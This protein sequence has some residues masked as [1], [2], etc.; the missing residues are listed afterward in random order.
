MIITEDLFNLQDD[1]AKENVIIT[2]GRL[3]HFAA[4]FVIRAARNL[5]KLPQ[6]LACL[7]D[8]RRRTKGSNPLFYSDSPVPVLASQL[9]RERY[10]RQKGCL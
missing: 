6:N 7:K 9:E 5:R 2:C 4:S 8:G 10:S 1:S 3:V